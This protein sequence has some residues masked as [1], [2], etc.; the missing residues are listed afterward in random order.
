MDNSLRFDCS[1]GLHHLGSSA[2]PLA[3]ELRER[4]ARRCP[5]SSRCANAASGPAPILSQSQVFGLAIPACP[6]RWPPLASWPPVLCCRRKPGKGRYGL[7]GGQGGWPTLLAP[8]LLTSSMRS[9]TRI[10][11]RDSHSSSRFLGSFFVDP[12]L[13]VNKGF[14]NPELLLDFVTDHDLE[15]A[16]LWPPAARRVLNEEISLLAEDGQVLAERWWVYYNTVRPHSSLGYR[17]PAPAARKIEASTGHGKVGSKERFPLLEWSAACSTGR[18][19]W[20]AGGFIMDI[21]RSAST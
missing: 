18:L 9:S 8:L 19:S 11:P 15:P 4:T 2:R 1:P 21:S 7:P 20:L 6:L 13:E 3:F 16:L 10:S 17:P 12:V 14:P 5:S